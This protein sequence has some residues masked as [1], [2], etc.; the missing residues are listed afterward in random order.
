MA[1]QCDE[2]VNQIHLKAEMTVNQ[3]VTAMGNAGAYN[4]GSLSR[5]VDIYEQMLRDPKSTE[6]IS[7]ILWSRMKRYGVSR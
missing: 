2:P 4:G 3:L 1:K 6:S 5:A 7:F